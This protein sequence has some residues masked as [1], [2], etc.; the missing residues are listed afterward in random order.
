MDAVVV[1][2]ITGMVLLI[3]IAVAT[4]HAQQTRQ[5]REIQERLEAMG[6]ENKRKE[7]ALRFQRTELLDPIS[8]LEIQIV[9]QDRKFLTEP[10]LA[11]IMKTREQVKK[12]T[13]ELKALE[14]WR[15]A[16]YDLE[17]AEYLDRV[18]A[19]KN[20]YMRADMEPP[21]DTLSEAASADSPQAS[22]TAAI[23]APSLTSGS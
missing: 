13:E 7:E 3:M 9:S 12:V 22:S 4:L 6:A 15:G 23:P 1:A 19:L 16:P 18:P 8:Q 10:E 17:W 11:T 21:A 2:M 5:L 14:A 20:L